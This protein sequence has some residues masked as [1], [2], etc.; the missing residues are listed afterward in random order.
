MIDSGMQSSSIKSYISGI[1]SMLGDDGYTL[2]ITKLKLTSLTKACRLTC[3]RVKTRLPIN[4][5]LLEII[6]FEV[7]RIFDND[8]VSQP[9]LEKLYKCLFVIAYY[10]LFRIGELA[11]SQHSV[12]AKDVH[13]A[14]NKNKNFG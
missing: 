4:K 3:D 10:G 13:V 6:L 12:R 2:D 1:K 8:E 7:G 11:E 9:Y 5:S 14:G